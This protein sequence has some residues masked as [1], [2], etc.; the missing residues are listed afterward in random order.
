MI[1]FSETQD[2]IKYTLFESSR[3]LERSKL[4]TL[5]T[6]VQVMLCRFRGFERWEIQAFLFDK[7]AF[8]SRA[9]ALKF[10]P[11][12]QPNS[13]KARA[14]QKAL[15]QGSIQDSGHSTFQVRSERGRVVDTRISIGY[16]YSRNRVYALCSHIVTSDL[17]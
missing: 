9:A 5:T 16:T 3:D 17:S 4:T 15:T 8:K 10:N 1:G 11:T 2:T 14:R 12:N 13:Q 6:G 7:S